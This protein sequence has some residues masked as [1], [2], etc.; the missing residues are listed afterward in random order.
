MSEAT[1]LFALFECVRACCHAYLLE[2]SSRP[3]STASALARTLAAHSPLIVER[4]D[5]A[6][7]VA[8]L[9]T[10]I[11]KCIRVKCE[12]FAQGLYVRVTGI[13]A[14]GLLQTHRRPMQHAAD[15]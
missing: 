5:L 13:F 11:R 14:R 1:R 9:G 15:D 10:V 7:C 3:V 4:G 8:H 6:W 2:Q 12:Q